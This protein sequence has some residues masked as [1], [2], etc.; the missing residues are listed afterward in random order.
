M[1]RRLHH[2]PFF[3]FLRI[4]L[5]ELYSCFLL[6][7]FSYILLASCFAALDTPSNRKILKMLLRR[8][9]VTCD[10][11]VN[12]SDG[13]EMVR[14]NGV[15]AYDL[16]FMDFTMPIMVS[17]RVALCALK[18]TAFIFLLLL[19]QVVLLRPSET[20]SMIIITPRCHHTPNALYIEWSSSHQG[21][22]ST[23]F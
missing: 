15:G 18:C 7:P 3:C 2:N 13:V 1:V 21:D 10:E 22:T 20:K 23:W 11:A 14:K 16:I 17:I 12:G 9:N 6:Y 4:V 8:K 19:P 5:E